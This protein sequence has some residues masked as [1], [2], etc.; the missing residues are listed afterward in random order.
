[1]K[2][3]RKS[4]GA[5]SYATLDIIL[6]KMPK[7]KSKRK[8]LK[9]FQFWDCLLLRV[10]LTIQL[11]LEFMIYKILKI[12]SNNNDDNIYN[13]TNNTCMR[14]PLAP[15]VFFRNAELYH[16]YIIIFSYSTG[17]HVLFYSATRFSGFTN[18]F[19]LSRV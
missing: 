12:N 15:D 9:C 10:L 5:I 16:L 8:E 3:R 14:E 19:Q 4:G 17:S 1:M 13:S 2:K 7:L 18:A 11:Y 6:P